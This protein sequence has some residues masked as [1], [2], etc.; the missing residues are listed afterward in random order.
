MLVFDK[1]GGFGRQK[2]MNVEISVTEWLGRTKYCKTEL[3][4]EIEQRHQLNSR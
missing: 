4:Y 3:K 2:D 1:H